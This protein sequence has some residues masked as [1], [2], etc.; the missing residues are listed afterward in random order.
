MVTNVKKKGY[1]KLIFLIFI[2]FLDALIL[3]A[4][5]SPRDG[6][7]YMFLLPLVYG[8]CLLLFNKV[9][10]CKELGIKVYNVIAFIRYII[11]PLLILLTAGEVSS[12][13]M[14]IVSPSSYYMSTFIQCV[15]III[16][17]ATISMFYNKIQEKYE[18]NEKEKGNYTIG[19]K[20][21]GIIVIISYLVVLL[22]RFPI[23]FP[24]LNIYGIKQ[25][26]TDGILLE[27]TLFSSVKTALF[28]YALDRTI[29]SNGKKRLVNLLFCIF[30]A[31]F[32]ILT[33]FGT[34]RALTLELT[35]T[36]IAMIV[37]YLPKYKK[38]ILT[39]IIPISIFMIFTMFVTKQFNIESTNE[40]SSV[41]LD[42]KYISNQLEEYTNG[43]WCIAQT[44][45]ASIGLS[46]SRSFR[47]ITKE[48]SNALMVVFVL[49]GL[50]QLSQKIIHWESSTDIF[51]AAFQNRNRG[52]IPS[53]S[54][55][56]FYCYGFLG[57]I[58]F[59]IGNFIAILFLLKYS[60]KSRLTNSLL[61]RYIYL[62]SSIV[63][64]LTHC[65]CVRVLLYCMSKYA[66]FIFLIILGNKYL[67]YKKSG[68][69][70][71]KS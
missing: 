19:I 6:L 12:N 61:E 22:Y 4:N 28:I 33:Y 56:F 17:Y 35:I 18:K 15:E 70:N 30:T 40:I 27:N 52:Q 43:P 42:L 55:G 45:E 47:A 14:S 20:T 54:A 26:I 23:W 31:L 59:P 29:K 39:I 66:W 57:F 10:K 68:E 71:E 49:P 46:L 50:Q 53:F 13:R 34:N 36:S 44:Y 7:E 41:T 51:R 1:F 65:Y 16:S 8:I 67:V 32:L 64:G 60:I 62:W 63:F 3:L 5:D 11:Q 21:G 38:M 24:A 37:H 2:S 9:L 69:T 58:L 48:L 25:S